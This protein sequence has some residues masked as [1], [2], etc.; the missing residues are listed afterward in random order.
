MTR[1]IEMHQWVKHLMPSLMTC[2]WSLSD[3]H[4]ENISEW[5]VREWV[6]KIIRGRGKQWKPERSGPFDLITKGSSHTEDY[7]VVNHSLWGFPW[8]GHSWFTFLLLFHCPGFPENDLCR[9]V[10]AC[11]SSKMECP[12]WYLKVSERWKPEPWAEADKVLFYER[13]CG[14]HTG[15]SQV[16][17]HQ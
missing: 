2:I 8:L 7:F 1:V 9:Q 15:R 14:T 17:P 6:R 11:F 5:E 13:R 16:L 12:P 3:G 4:S 10:K